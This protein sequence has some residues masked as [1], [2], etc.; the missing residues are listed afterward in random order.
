MLEIYIHIGWHV[1]LA[2]HKRGAL[3]YTGSFVA[4]DYI[5]TTSRQSGIVLYLKHIPLSE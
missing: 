5:V 1:W 2:V 4:R 3:A